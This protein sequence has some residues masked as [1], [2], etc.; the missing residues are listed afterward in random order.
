M[1]L[2][3]DDFYS[4]RHPASHLWLSMISAQTPFAFVSQGKPVF[5][6]MR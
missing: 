4:D 2:E 1:R 5:R 3:Q 6:I